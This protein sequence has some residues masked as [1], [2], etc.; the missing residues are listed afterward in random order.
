MDNESELGG[1]ARVAIADRVYDEIQNLL[2]DGCF[3][4]GERMSVD[5]L[6]RRLG[7]SQTPVRAALS[8]L[9]AEDLVVKTHLIGYS[10]GPKLSPSRFED[11]FE[12]RFLLEPHCAGLAAARHQ[13]EQVDRIAHLNAEMHRGYAA[14][15]L[16]YGAFARRDAELHE[17][18]I[19]ATGNGYYQELFGKLHC[20]LHL[21]RLMR[22]SRVTSDALDEHDLIVTALARRDAE[23]AA[24]AMRAHLEASRGRL[25]AAFVD[26]R[27]PPNVEAL[28]LDRPRKEARGR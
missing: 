16:S 18:I 17:A 25:R 19:H 26:E 5:A 28:P 27:R 7:V 11:L 20:H 2:I 6:S 3:Q 22:D 8:R 12:V 10:A 13:H 23:G 14:D 15:E 4:P 9:E 21:F 24:A 1:A